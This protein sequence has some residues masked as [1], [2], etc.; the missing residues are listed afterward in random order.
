MTVGHHASL[1]VPQVSTITTLK[2]IEQIGVAR[3]WV[4]Q[5]RLSLNQSLGGRYL[6]NWI[7]MAHMRQ[8]LHGYQALLLRQIMEGCMWISR[9]EILITSSGQWSLAVEVAT[10]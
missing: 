7:A 5:P 1:L 8:Q 6:K 2:S 9:T 4:I 10:M 3:R